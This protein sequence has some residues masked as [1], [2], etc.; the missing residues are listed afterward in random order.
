MDVA[1]LNAINSPDFTRTNGLRKAAGEANPPALT[2][3]ESK[4]IQKEFSGTQSVTYYKV[5]GQ[6]QEQMVAARGQHLDKTI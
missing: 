1:S 3:N 5:N 6:K 2:E 4:M